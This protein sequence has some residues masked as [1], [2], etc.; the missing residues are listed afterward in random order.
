[1]GSWFILTSFWEGSFVLNT[2]YRIFRVPTGIYPKSI[3]DCSEI[4]IF[5]VDVVVTYKKLTY[6]DASG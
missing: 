6:A 2:N 5:Y 4:K 3:S 1:M